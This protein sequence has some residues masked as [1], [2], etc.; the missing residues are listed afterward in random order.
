MTKSPERREACTKEDNWD[1]WSEIDYGPPYA[2]WMR[3]PKVSERK[4]PRQRK[5][6]LGVLST[7]LEI[8]RYGGALN[9]EIREFMSEIGVEVRLLVGAKEEY[10]VDHDAGKNQERSSIFGVWSPAAGSTYWSKLM[11]SDAINVTPGD[12]KAIHILI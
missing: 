8:V 11:P 12:G 10:N 1:Y 5:R 3:V 7:V 2:S 9:P 4:T 6:H